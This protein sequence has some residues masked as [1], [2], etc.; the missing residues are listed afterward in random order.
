MKIT[1]EV[2]DGY[3]GK[4]RPQHIE[5]PDDELQECINV[6][7][8]FTLIE[9]YVQAAFE[10]TITFTFRVENDELPKPIGEIDE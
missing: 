9:E 6:E 5:V 8:Q 7:E 10:N 4:S 1:W 2:D 3:G